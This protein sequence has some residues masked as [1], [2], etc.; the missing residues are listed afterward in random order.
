MS[1]I[2]DNPVLVLD[3]VF[4][5]PRE[6]GTEGKFLLAAVPVKVC[7]PYEVS[8]AVFLVLEAIEIVKKMNVQQHICIFSIRL[9]LRPCIVLGQH[10]CFTFNIN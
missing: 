2:G 10:P 8:D 7:D 5:E 4:E 1:A 6:R 3:Y 9:S